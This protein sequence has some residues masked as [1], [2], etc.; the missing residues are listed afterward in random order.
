MKTVVTPP[1]PKKGIPPPKKAEPVSAQD[2]GRT[3]RKE[4]YINM[5]EIFLN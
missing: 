3:K 5:F 1:S 2:K 4:I